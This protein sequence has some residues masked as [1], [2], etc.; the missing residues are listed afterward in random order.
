MKKNDWMT[1]FYGVDWFEI[2]S[3]D[4]LNPGLENALIEWRVSAQ[5]PDSINKAESN[6]FKLVESAIEFESQVTPDISKD[7]SEIELAKE[8]HLDQIIDITQKCFLDNNDLYTRFKNKEFFT[9]EQCRSYYE[10]SI[11]NNFSKQ[12]TVTVVSQDEEG[13]SAYYMIR[14]VDEN[15]YKGVMTGVLPRARGKRL[16]AK[17]QQASFN[18]IGKTITV[19]NSTQL[20]NFN[21]IKSHIRANRILSKIDHIFYLRV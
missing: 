1:D 21:T 4:E 13:I 19:I 8:E 16:H 10:A 12:S 14:K 5:N 11:K 18:A 7:T 17:M 3:I 2:T 15:I 9:G 6:G 20:S